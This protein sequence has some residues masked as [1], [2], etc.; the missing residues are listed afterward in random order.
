MTVDE[1]QESCQ[2]QEDLL[3]TWT[4]QELRDAFDD[5]MSC[6]GDAT[7]DEI[8]DGACYDASLWSY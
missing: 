3:K 5:E 2:T 4:D 8:A 1:C 7:C 6:L